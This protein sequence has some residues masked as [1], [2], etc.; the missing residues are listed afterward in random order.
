MWRFFHRLTGA[1]K[2]CTSCGETKAEDLFPKRRNVCK[3][4]WV[5]RNK[6]S[7]EKHREARVAQKKEHYAKNRERIK[8]QV[9]QYRKEHPEVLKSYREKNKDVLY[10]KNS[11]WRKANPEKARAIELRRIP[12]EERKKSGIERLKKWSVENAEAAKVARREAARRFAKNN[13]HKI[14]ASNAR[15]RS[16]TNHKLP[17]GQ[18]GIADVYAE[19]RYF[20]MHVDHIVPLNHP[21][22]CGLHVWDNLQLL[23]RSE[24]SSKRNR[25]DQDS[26]VHTSLGDQ[27]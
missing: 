15:R 10:K 7:F 17:W 8:A 27:K 1:M 2:K 24:N 23:S 22:V 12:S 25:F 20:G 3:K 13:P 5:A 11:E 19:A 21:L 6:I 26:H 18:E 14:A 9:A 16:Q 4:C